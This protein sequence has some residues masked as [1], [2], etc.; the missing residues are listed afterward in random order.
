MNPELIGSDLDLDLHLIAR[1]GLMADIG[2]K[3]WSEQTDCTQVAG[4]G[5][6][7]VLRKYSEAVKCSLRAAAPARYLRIVHRCYSDLVPLKCL[8]IVE[9]YRLAVPVRC[10]Q[11]DTNSRS[12]SDQDQDLL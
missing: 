6:V 12:D 11:I 4:F 3:Q 2:S 1:D 8:K 5:R 9:H 7:A 10:L